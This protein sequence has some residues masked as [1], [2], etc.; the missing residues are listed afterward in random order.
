VSKNSLVVS[1]LVIVFLH[2]V[3]CAIFV[4]QSTITQM[5]SKDADG[6]KSVIKSMDTQDYGCFGMGNGWKS[7][8]GRSRGFFDLEQVSHE[9]T[10]SLTAFHILGHRKSRDTSSNVLLNPK[11]PTAGRSCR[12]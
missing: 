7:P 9:S 4:S 10:K 6:G 8:C 2:G 11:C 3:K 12:V 1:S 5:E